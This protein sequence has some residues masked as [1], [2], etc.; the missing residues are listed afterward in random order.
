M[1]E[2]ARR[3]MADMVNVDGDSIA[4]AAVAF[5]VGWHAANQAVA[6]YTDPVIDDETTGAGS[7]RSGWTRNG[8]STPP[9]TRR[10]VFTTQI[11]DLDR[12][13]CPRRDRGPLPGRAG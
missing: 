7:R 10:T 12:H 6:D 5:G 1:T 13:R 3:R 9:R 2:R 8:S 4:A 11:V